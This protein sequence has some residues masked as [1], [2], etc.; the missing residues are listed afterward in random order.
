[1]LL[2]TWVY[3]YPCCVTSLTLLGRHLEG[4]QLGQME[5][6]AHF[7][8]G[9]TSL[10]LTRIHRRAFPGSLPSLFVWF[11]FGVRQNL[12]VTLICI[13]MPVG[14]VQHFFMYLLSTCTSSTKFLFIS[15]FF[16]FCFAGLIFWVFCI[17]YVVSVRG[18]AGKNFPIVCLLSLLIVSFIIQKFLYLTWSHVDF[19]CYFLCN[20]GSVWKIFTYAYKKTIFNSWKCLIRTICSLC[21]KKKLM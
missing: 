21:G 15:S 12:R 9:C 19:W 20:W 16:K 17:L 18:I 10:F 5:S 8:S 14:D 7:P 2:H 6:C 4:G 1:M 13:S 3:S 11:L